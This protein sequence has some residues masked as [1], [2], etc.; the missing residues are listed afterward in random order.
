[1][2]SAIA[3]EGEEKK[4]QGGQVR[5][6]FNGTLPEEAKRGRGNNFHDELVFLCTKTKKK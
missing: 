1:M 2:R 5:T 4:T 6:E 3:F